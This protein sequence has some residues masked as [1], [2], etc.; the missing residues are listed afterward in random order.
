[1]E[2]YVKVTILARTASTLTRWTS[3]WIPGSLSIALILTCITFISAFAVETITG[4]ETAGG[5]LSKC[6]VAWGEG[7]WT[8]L[9]FAMQMCLVIL[10]GY[11]IAVSSPVRRLLKWLISIPRSPSGVVVLVAL[12][13]MILSWINW[14]LGLVT[15]AM[16]LRTAVS[17]RKRVEIKLLAAAA[18]L[19][20]G[21]TWHAGLSGSVPLLLA[22]PGHFLSRS[23]GIVPISQTI[24]TS[25]NI[26]LVIV[27]IIA[28]AIAVKMM[29][30]ES[31]EIQELNLMEEGENEIIEHAEHR[32]ES[33]AQKIEYSRALN[34]LIGLLGGAY[35]IYELFFKKSAFGLNTL[36]LLFL[37]IGIFLHKNPASLAK[38]AERGSRLL[39]GIVLQFPI[40]AGIFGIIKGTL[41]VKILSNAFVFVAST[42]TFPL[43]VTVYSAFMN[44]FVPSGGSKWA[45]EAPYLIEA[46]AR[47]HVPVAKAAMAY[48]YGDMWTNLIQPFWAI[49]IMA[50]ARLEFKDIMGYGLI[51]GGVYGIIICIA[52]LII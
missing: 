42:K 22:T 46:S 24:F 2:V 13:S 43:I 3:K 9:E 1:M 45:I 32:M 20:L 7:V 18:Y 52:M 39:H 8:L 4:R 37:V 28:V 6:I 49:P 16:L 29:V 23:T 40:Y 11:L 26:I 10:T 14:G 34:V 15:G 19:G 5:G 25:F 30:P 21:T 36:N 35:L 50:A 17:M 51:I 44:Y 31:V 41:L 38:A 33:F 48:A 47:L 27:I 12:I